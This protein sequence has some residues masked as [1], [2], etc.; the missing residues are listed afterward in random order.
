MTLGKLLKRI[1]VDAGITQDDLA[2]ELGI[3]RATLSHYESDR[4]VPPP[5]KLKALANYYDI[6]LERLM[7]KIPASIEVTDQSPVQQS[8]EDALKID[9]LIYFYRNVSDSKKEIIYNLASAL[10]KDQ[11]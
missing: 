3:K 6:S 11:T 8:R 7:K 9:E 10:Y 4:I 1:R 2:N 5:S